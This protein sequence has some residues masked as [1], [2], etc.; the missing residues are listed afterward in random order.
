MAKEILIGIYQ[1]LNLVNGKCYVGSSSNIQN[2]WGQHLHLLRLNKHKNKK[3]QNAW[4]KYGENEFQFVILEK[5][6]NSELILNEQKHIDITKC[7][8]FGYNI[9]EKAGRERAGMKHTPEAI[10]KMSAAHLGKTVGLEHRAKLSAALKGRIFSDDTKA[11]IS[12]AKTGKKR[13]P[14]TD[15][16]KLNMSAATKGRVHSPESRAAMSVAHKGKVMSELARQN[17]SIAQRIRFAK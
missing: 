7:V 12:A 10:L 9:S 1:I 17:M 14:F 4:L 5:C 15:K 11:K 16:A 2:R 13:L 6:Q 8:L 3:L